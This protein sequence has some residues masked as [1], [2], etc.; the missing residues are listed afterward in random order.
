MELDAQAAAKDRR[1]AY[2]NLAA[3]G[4]LTLLCC[5]GGGGLTAAL[6]SQSESDGVAAA[7]AV[8]GPLCCSLAG[9]L[10]AVPG[11]FALKGKIP[12]KIGLPIALGVAGGLVGVVGVVVFFEAIFPA[13]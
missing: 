4:G 11:L 9:L 3:W 5:C 13:L 7:Y 2:L 12:L 8:T 10:G 6:G 1:V